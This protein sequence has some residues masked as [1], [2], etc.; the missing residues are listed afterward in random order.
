MVVKFNPVLFTL[1]VVVF[2]ILLHVSDARDAPKKA[3]VGGWKPITDIKDPEVVETGKFA[4]DEHNKE[5]KMVL[6]FQEVTKGE[7]QVVQGINY[8]LT[9]S[10][11]DSDSLHNYLAEVW[12]K[13][14]GKSKKLT[15]FEELK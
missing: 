8:R 2:T 1:L 13:P 10:A 14:G 6:E 11:K 7:S 15:S 4:V 9:I 12:V 3:L 5:A